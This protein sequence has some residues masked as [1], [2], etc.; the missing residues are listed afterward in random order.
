MPMS[1]EQLKFLSLEEKPARLT[2]EQ[3]AWALNC[4]QH[5]IRTLVNA[6]LLKPLGDPADNAVKYF[7][8]FE[9]AELARNRHWL[10]KATQAIYEHWQTK[11]HGPSGK[12]LRRLGGGNRQK[13]VVS[14]RRPAETTDE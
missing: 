4:Q 5:D 9:L 1:D 12:N 14:H 7:A 3:T 6:R 10:D 2:V 11:N 8:A 13:A